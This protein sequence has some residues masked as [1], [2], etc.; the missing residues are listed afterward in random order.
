MPIKK[1]E[2]ESLCEQLPRFILPRVILNPV[3]KV[4]F[5]DWLLGWLLRPLVG[6]LLGWLLGSLLGSV[7]VC[8]LD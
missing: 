4:R 2:D 7:F 3:L 6:S 1:F 5:G 8:L